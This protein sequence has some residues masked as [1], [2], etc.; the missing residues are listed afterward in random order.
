MNSKS[1][2]TEPITYPDVTNLDLIPNKPPPPYHVLDEND[3]KKNL[4]QGIFD[5]ETKITSL[6]YENAIFPKLKKDNDYP[7]STNKKRKLSLS[8][9]DT[10]Y[11]DNHI[12][13]PEIELSDEQES[14]LNSVV[15]D[16][17]SLFISGS[18]GV[19]KSF[20]LRE[21]IKKL[22]EI[23]KLGEVAITASTGIAACNI[24]G[25]TLHW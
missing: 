22:K 6:E 7:D 16:K 5:I 25:C 3:I 13:K 21:I 15:Y 18:A 12:H 9:D 24:G 11:Q 19:G 17:E 2:N 14:I 10:K 4:H 1:R 8:S 20:L 23:Y